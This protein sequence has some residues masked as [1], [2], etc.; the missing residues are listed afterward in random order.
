M[1][2]KTPLTID[3]TVTLNVNNSTQ[4][5]RMCAAGRGLPPLLV[6]QCGPA[7][8]L[9][10]DVAKFQRLLKLEEDFLGRLGNILAGVRSRKPA[11]GGALDTP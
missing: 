1:R 2:I 8:P 5:V 4:Q 3:Q 7:L 10:H 9:L 6:V 11:R